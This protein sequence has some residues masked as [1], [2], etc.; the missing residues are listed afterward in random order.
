MLTLYTKN[1]KE[2]AIRSSSSTVHT[3][4]GA[5]L[6][7]KALPGDEVA[8]T[9]SGCTLVSRNQTLPIAGL[10]E[11]NSKTKYGFTSKNHPIY[12]F[13][14]F[15]EAYP[16]FV[17]GSSER[18]TSRNRQA[19]IKFE[20]WTTDTFPR[21]SLIKFLDT[22]EEA[23]SWTY[24]PLACLPYKGLLPLPAAATLTL[25]S[26][27]PIQAF[28]IDPLGCRDVDDVLTI[29]S[30]D[31]VTYVTITISDVAAH[32]PE[33]S[34]LDQRAQQIAQTFYQD[35]L[36]PRHVFPPELSEDRLSLLPLLEPT[37]QKLGLSLKFPL[38]DPTKVTW[39]ESTVQTTKT[40]TYE[41]VYDD[42]P[43]CKDLTAMALALGTATDDSHKWIEA[44]MKFYN[45]QAATLLH[46]A[47]SGLLRSH[48]A[49][50]EEKLQNLTKINPDLQFLAYKSALYVPATD[51][52][53]R[54]FGLDA[55]F[56]T[57]ATSPIRR[58]ADLVNQRVIKRILQE[59]D[60]NLTAQNQ[61]QNQNQLAAHLND[62]AKQ[63][64]RHD[65]DLTF[66][67]ALKSGN[68]QVTGQILELK[69]EDAN[70]RLS[71]YV[72]AW[73]LSV[74][75]RYKTKS[76]MQDKVTVIS[77]DET[78]E[79]TVALGQTVTMDYRADMTARNWK[80]RMVL[81]LAA[82]AAAAAAIT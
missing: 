67:R 41:S 35:G 47:Q 43:L 57:H 40:Y 54:H 26:R 14:P 68:S 36:K 48:L 56:Y 65:R 18:D 50:D 23:L 75:L 73:E 24:T 77:K 29:D 21:G 7:N 80:K 46:K 62:R 51:P 20:S 28:H 39:F 5:K 1:Y 70:T 10:L 63:A 31:G 52:N 32:I 19:I 3:F 11:L 53:P 64:K 4:S 25:D 17:V 71:I 27:L 2:F 69:A 33:G 37:A 79:H 49:P 72:P 22:E 38:H 34:P 59:Q 12:L 45:V 44:A 61:D 15:N 8:A 76:Q 82:T 30:Q 42:A 66:I 9:S 78:T 16:P 74:K 13:I 6:A 58:Y 81:R 60:Q 55:D